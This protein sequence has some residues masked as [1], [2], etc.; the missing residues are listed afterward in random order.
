MINFKDIKVVVSDLDGTLT[1]GMYN[2]STDGNIM[3][4]FYT[5]DFYGLEQLMDQGIFVLI[6]TASHDDC[7]SVRMNDL[8][9]KSEKWKNFYI[10]ERFNFL[11]G[12][13]K[14]KVAVIE[15]FL[16]QHKFNWEN[17]AYIGDSE[18]DLECMKNSR[19]IGCPNDAIKSIKELEGIYVSD[20]NGGKG[21][22]YDFVMNFL[23]KGY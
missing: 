17:V 12:A 6:I 10:N 18:N 2:V 3:K 14:E 13:S 8:Y 19:V 23:E 4:S 15:K 22:V 7:M 11:K 1:D 16:S 20:Y 21:A 9:R 5:R